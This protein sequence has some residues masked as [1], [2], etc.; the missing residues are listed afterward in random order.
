MDTKL[1][2][3]VVRDSPDFLGGCLESCV[4]HRKNY[5]PVVV[6]DQ[7]I[8]K[9]SKGSSSVGR[10]KHFNRG[11]IP[12]DPATTQVTLTKQEQS[13]TEE[14]DNQVKIW[15]LIQSNLV[16]SLQNLERL[17]VTA[18]D[19]LE[20][21][22]QLEGL[23]VEESQLVFD[24]LTEL[25]LFSLSKLVHIWKK[26]PQQ[27]RG[28]GNLKVLRVEGCGSLK[29]LFSPFVAKLL[30]KL[31]KMEVSKCKEMDKIHAKG[32]GGEE[33]ESEV[34]VFPRVNS[35]SLKDLPKLEC[36]CNEANAFEWPSLETIRIVRCNSLKMFVP[37]E[38]KTPNLQGVYTDDDSETL[39]PMIIK[40]KIQQSP[41][42]MIYAWVM[43]NVDDVW[44]KALWTRAN[45]D[46]FLVMPNHSRVSDHLFLTKSVTSQDKKRLA[47]TS[48]EKEG[49]R[50]RSERA[51]TYD[52]PNFC[53]GCNGDLERWEMQHMDG[54]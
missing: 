21:I 19:L 31:E 4:P 54:L 2:S 11:Q 49:K 36:F 48:L 34:I 20:V 30:V 26:G 38:M 53:L 42:E 25:S 22:F 1:D 16:E 24:N 7:S 40:G 15:S 8:S 14:T 6:S 17:D 5:K 32:L 43:P 9:R 27:I 28:F 35:L 3:R 29:Y 46:R 12:N 33:E 13:V 39:Q 41:I 37:K 52:V 10:T 50:S 45:I 51:V 23:L 18:C 47:T 44:T